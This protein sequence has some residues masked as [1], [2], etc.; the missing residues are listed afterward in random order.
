MYGG[1]TV[2]RPLLLWTE[3]PVPL[4][5]E[6]ETHDWMEAN[7]PWEKFDLELVY[8]NSPGDWRHYDTAFRAAWK[9]A[10]EEQR[11]FLNLESDIVPTELAFRQL[12]ECTEPI[13]TVPYVLFPNGA[14]VRGDYSAT[15]EQRVPGGWDAH[16]AF[17]GDPRAEDSDLGF[18][19]FRSD[20]CRFNIDEVAPLESDSGLL[21]YRLFQ[22]LGTKLGRVGLIHLHWPAIRNN[23][24][25]WDPGDFAHHPAGYVP[26]PG[27]LLS[28][29]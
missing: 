26:P 27:L 8:D 5:R 17:E 12:L 9:Q 14:Q 28:D 22:W 19:R 24:T 23:H 11:P 13:C 21:N 2:N 20:I 29:Q 18:V 1:Q 25:H 16:F 7:R 6:L 15:V 10:G 3:R 4:K